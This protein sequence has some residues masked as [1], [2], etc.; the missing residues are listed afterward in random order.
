MEDADGIA[1]WNASGSGKKLI[2][3]AGSRTGQLDG[4]G[5]DER[6]GERRI[7]E[8]ESAKPRSHLSGDAEFARTYDSCYSN[9][10]K[11]FSRHERG[12]ASSKVCVKKRGRSSGCISRIGKPA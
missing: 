10:S 12:K 11:P 1:Q 4:R 2:V 6:A 3:T 8:R 7:P 5:H 9:R